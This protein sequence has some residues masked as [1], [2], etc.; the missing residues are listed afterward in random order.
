ME[1]CISLFE[2]KREIGV[3]LNIKENINNCLTIGHL[4]C[5]YVL[6]VSPSGYLSQMLWKA[7]KHLSVITQFT[8]LRDVL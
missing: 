5:F 2:G 6:S 3:F 8:P 4:A 1:L 7:D